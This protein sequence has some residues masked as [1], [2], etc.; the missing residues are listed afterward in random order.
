MFHEP[1]TRCS[2][3]SSV[4]YARSKPPIPASPMLGARASQKQRQTAGDH[5]QTPRTPR[6]TG[7]APCWTPIWTPR[8]GS[9]SSTPCRSPRTPQQAI[10]Q[11]KAIDYAEKQEVSESLDALYRHRKATLRYLRRCEDAKELLSL[12]QA[13]NPQPKR[14]LG[15][16]CPS[17]ALQHRFTSPSLSVRQ[18]RSSTPQREVIESTGSRLPSRAPSAELLAASPRLAWPARAA[19]AE[20][21]SQLTPTL[22]LAPRPDL[23]RP[24]P[25]G[26]LRCPKGM[27][28]LDLSMVQPRPMSRSPVF[29][30]PEERQQSALR[31]SGLAGI[32]H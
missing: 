19:V 28:F 8:P 26:T 6:S 10:L 18:S 31:C 16:S 21:S 25:C 15:S 7:K 13:L 17:P 24:V 4:G 27:T 3:S 14:F 12:Q 5:P 2:T 32:S 1:T 11:W 23:C 29:S 9:G 20:P 22:P 30:S